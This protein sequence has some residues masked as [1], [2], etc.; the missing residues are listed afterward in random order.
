MTIIW[1]LVLSAT[2]AFIAML[3][4]M[5]NTILTDKEYISSVSLK[6]GLFLIFAIMLA[7][8]CLSFIAFLGLLTKALI[9]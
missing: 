5:I 3:V 2:L 6:Y 9:S 1:M 7:G 8:S 4:H